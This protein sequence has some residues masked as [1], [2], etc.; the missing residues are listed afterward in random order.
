MKKFR[1]LYPLLLTLLVG[2]AQANALAQ[3]QQRLQIPPL[4]QCEFEQQRTLQ[5]M[6]QPLRSQGTIIMDQQQGMVFQQKQPFAQLI[7]LTETRLYQD[8][9]GQIQMISAQE[10][11]QIFHFSQLIADLLQGKWQ[12]LETNFTLLSPTITP[13]Q[14]QVSLEPKT[15]PLN[16]LFKQF[17]L[18]GDRL[19]ERVN[20]A[21]QQG[22]FTELRFSQCHS[23]AGLSDEQQ[24]YFAD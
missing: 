5:G 2:N 14:W 7:V 1:L 22:D 11:P 16:V 18:R 23:L 15:A 13:E 17:E 12:T 24:R 20:I 3:I 21:D 8:I 19:L 9:Q 4:L 6:S 10:Q